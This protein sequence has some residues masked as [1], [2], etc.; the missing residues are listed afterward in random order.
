MKNY[1]E[2]ELFDI[3]INNLEEELQE[4]L[5]KAEKILGY[6]ADDVNMVV[7]DLLTLN[8]EEANTLATDI[9][10]LEEDMILTEEYYADYEEKDDPFL[11]LYDSDSDSDLSS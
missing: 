9:M 2:S 1:D 5:D 7:E 3:Q 10:D 4:L 11:N 6:K 8:S